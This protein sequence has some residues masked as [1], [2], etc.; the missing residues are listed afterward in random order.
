M[1]GPWRATGQ[2]SA[3][4]ALAWS[5][6]GL[7]GAA[8]AA[9]AGLHRASYERGW[10]S[11]TRLPCAVVSVGNLSLGGSAKTPVAAW[12]ARR[13]AAHRRVALASRGYGRERA[14]DLAVVSDGRRV[15]ARLDRAGDEPL[16]LAAH[17]PGVPVVVARDRG[18]AGRRAVGAFDSEVLVLDDGFQHHRLHRDLDIVLVDAAAGFGNRRVFPRGPLREPMSVL[19]RANAV[20]IVDGPLGG[21]DA[22]GL[23]RFAPGARRFA[24]RRR[25]V[26]LRPLGG[27]VPGRPDGCAVPAEFV[28]G[29]ELGVLTALARP[30]NLVRQI[31]KLGGRV[32]AR[33]CFR[34]HHRYRPRDLR[35]LDR[36]APL[37]ITTEKD[38]F[39]IRPEWALGVDLQVAAMEVEIDAAAE[40][41]AWVDAR[42]GDVV[43]RQRAAG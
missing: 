30:E 27:R 8:V 39:K 41:V 31:E 11:R 4:A 6:L 33:R 7:A 26:G 16:V 36:R 17:A 24:V 5:P 25:L 18:V 38:A 9:T 13:L 22:A 34:D 1:R 28:A 15:T 14:D 10:R 20:G 12:L 21:A 40:F 35:G 32:V 23:A 3:W 43:E 29:R 19:A 37:W 42:V 2:E